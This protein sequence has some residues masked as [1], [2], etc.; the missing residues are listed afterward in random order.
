MIEQVHDLPE[1]SSELYEK[2]RENMSQGRAAFFLASGKMA[3]GKDTI[4]AG[5]MAQAGYPDA[6]AHSFATALKEDV[7]IMLAITREGGYN[8]NSIVAFCVNHLRIP[9]EQAR[10]LAT[11]LIR[12]GSQQAVTA[13]SRTSGMRELLQYYGAD[14]RRS[15]QDDY[16]VVRGLRNILSDLA[17]GKSVYVTDAR[18]PNEIIHSSNA[19]ATVVRLTVSPPEQRVRLLSRDGVLPAESA[20]SHV[21][22]TSLDTFQ[23]DHVINTDAHSVDAVIELASRT[24]PRA[25]VF[26]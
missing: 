13:R 1:L 11:M 25:A 8:R 10:K 24:L 17:D 21:S 7:N 12:E 2:A 15:Q 6:A 5:V 9:A 20:F 22:E 23:F 4:G 16:W 26:A 14:V 18:F 19:G 3:S